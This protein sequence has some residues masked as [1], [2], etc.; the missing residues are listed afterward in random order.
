MKYFLAV[1]GGGSKTEALL[2]DETG[3][4]VG[5]GRGGPANYHMAGMDGAMNAIRQAITSALQGRTPTVSCFCLAAADM[6]HDFAE[7]HRGLATL[8]LTGDILL[9]NDVINV[10]RAGSRFPYGV[11]VVCGTGFGAG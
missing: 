8:G 5:E 7:L 1:D 10:F 4:T 6:P 2:V 9:Y 3:R 11:G